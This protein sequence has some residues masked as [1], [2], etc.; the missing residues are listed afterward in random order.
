VIVSLLTGRKG[1]KGF[2]DKHFYNI[3]GH[4]LSYYPIRAARK[5]KSIDKRYISTDDEDLMKLAEENNIEVI[6]R[7]SYLSSDNALSEDVFVHGYNIIQERN[8][9]KKI[10][11]I[12]LLM[13]NA[14]AVTSSIIERGINVLVANSSYDSAVTVS[15]YNMWGPIRARKIGKDGFLYPFVSFDA[16]ENSKDFSCDRNSQG[17]VWFAD[18]GASI[19]RYHCLENIRNG[20]LPQKWMGN[21]IYPLKH[22]MGL[23]IDYDWQVLQAEQWL[24]LYGEEE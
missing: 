1:S 22:E 17:D 7:P 3:L 20:M 14:F 18:H 10:D 6:K 24:K 4:E 23:D 21:R 8:S 9:N 16:Y 19:V 12:V 15:K 11:I 5:C 2:P 13:C